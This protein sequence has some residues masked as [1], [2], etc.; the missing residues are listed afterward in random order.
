[1]LLAAASQ[2]QDWQ[3]IGETAKTT[4]YIDLASA[5]KIGDMRRV[6]SVS[7]DKV[8]I[9]DKGN[10]KSARNLVELDCKDGRFRMLSIT[11][12]SGPMLRGER[13]TSLSSDEPGAW[14][15]IPPG[16][17]VEGIQKIVCP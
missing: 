2:A 17:I 8:D 12:Y 3:R 11:A 5:K 15:Y 6:W 14:A 7:D 10:P 9:A 16:T 1:M 13:I 4:Y